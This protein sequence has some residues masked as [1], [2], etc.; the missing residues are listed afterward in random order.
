MCP[1]DTEGYPWGTVGTAFDYRIRYRYEVTAIRRLV[2]YKG[3]VMAAGLLGCEDM[4]PPAFVELESALD[5]LM[6]GIADLSSP[7]PVDQEERLCRLCYALALYEQHYRGTANENWPLVKL[8]PEATLEQI[9]KLCSP[10]V[11]ED[12]VGMSHLFS[13]C[14]DPALIGTPAVLNPTFAGS[15]EL[16][17]ADADLI[18]GRTLIDLKTTK[19]GKPGRALYWQIVGYALADYTNEYDID[20]V[21]FYFARYGSVVSWPLDDLLQRLAGKPVDIEET[22]AEFKKLLAGLAVD[23]RA[24]TKAVTLISR[25]GYV[26]LGPV[27]ERKVQFRP[28]ASGRGK[29]HLPYTE[30]P[31]QTKSDDL[32]HPDRTPACGSNSAL[33]PGA[34]PVSPAVGSKY[35]DAD[36]RLCRRCLGYTWNFY[37][38]PLASAHSGGDGLG[39][40]TSGPSIEQVAHHQRRHVPVVHE[41]VGGP[42][43][44]QRDN[45]AGW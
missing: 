40:P 17:G 25:T 43:L 8:G 10:R 6:G 37:A 31:G 34:E 36:P 14:P 29:W 20:R 13:E 9:V 18:L 19:K 22:R 24:F 35:K 21:G 11:V 26:P 5:H 41:V 32:T 39:I 44:Q 4:L 45:D 7:L 27:V 38:K 12:L 15:V 16:G 28:P 1:A 2:A 3:A 33:D 23:A 42:D 30:V